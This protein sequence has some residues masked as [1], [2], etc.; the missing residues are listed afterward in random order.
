MSSN[1]I[2]LN[3][4]QQKLHGRVIDEGGAFTAEC[5]TQPALSAP[6]TLEGLERQAF[7]TMEEARAW[8]ERRSQERGYGQ[9]WM[10]S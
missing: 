3:E 7:P 10:D 8:I 2:S 5:W 1:T 9:V 6:A 4:G